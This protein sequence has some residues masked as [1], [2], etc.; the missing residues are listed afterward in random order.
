M[1]TSIE[2]TFGASTGK[3]FDLNQASKPLDQCR[4]LASRDRR[5]ESDPLGAY[6]LSVSRA[7]MMPED[8]LASP[9]VFLA[10]E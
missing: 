1:C 10:T 5:A 4:P 7:I 3:L 8:P 2:K 6:L 9:M